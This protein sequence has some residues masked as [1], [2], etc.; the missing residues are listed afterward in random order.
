M[1]ILYVGQ[2]N[3]GGTCLDRMRS[4]QRLNHDV[5][6]FDVLSYQSRSRIACSIQSR[7]QPRI[8]LNDLNVALVEAVR[9]FR[10][11][12]LIWIDKGVWI[13]PETLAF[14][15]RAADGLLVHYTPDAQIL[16]NRSSHF[17]SAISLYDCLITTKSFELERLRALGAKHALLV[18]QSYCPVRYLAPKRS[19]RFDAHV[20]FVS[21]FKPP[22]G[23]RISELAKGVEG[24]RVW[25]PRWRRAA[26]WRRIPSAV[27]A[28]DGIWGEDYVNA[29]ASFDIGLG[30]LSKYIPEQHT[31]RTFEIPAA[32]TFLLA[33]R[34]DEHCR[35]FTEGREA[36]FFDSDEELVSKSKFY[37]RNDAARRRIAN[38][39]YL[40]CHRSGY[41]TDAV[42]GKILGALG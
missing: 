5:V 25:G 3:E 4:L 22:Y 26:R 23:K 40:R 9:N 42:L 29:L 14:I 27:V 20:G 12:N 10:G 13:Y 18:S 15:K 41:D 36:E 7:W 37:I 33:E 16:D 17:L 39:G 28:G 24:V 34:T 35:F 30:L 2:L 32:G 1:K 21:D 38:N 31:T 6:G 8:L 11:A 19:A